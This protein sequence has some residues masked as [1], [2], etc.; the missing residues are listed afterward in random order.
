MTAKS[1]STT[2][3]RQKSTVLD[4]TDRSQVTTI[5][6]MLD[7]LVSTAKVCKNFQRSCNC[8]MKKHMNCSRLFLSVSSISRLLIERREPLPNTYP[9]IGLVC[10][11]P[12]G[13]TSP[14]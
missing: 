13:S 10:K 9:E 4:A 12:V 5:G 2:L 11:L 3:R 8:V 14:P 1:L 6:H 7:S